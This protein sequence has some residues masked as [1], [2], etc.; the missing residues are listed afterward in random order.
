M[1]LKGKRKWWKRK[2][3]P[4]LIRPPHAAHGTN[5]RLNGKSLNDE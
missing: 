5:R 2:T 1:T 3:V 4:A